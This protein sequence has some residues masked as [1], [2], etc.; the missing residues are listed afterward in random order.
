M[1]NDNVN[2]CCNSV[3]FHPNDALCKA[4]FLVGAIQQCIREVSLVKGV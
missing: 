1:S 4:R 3:I 2:K